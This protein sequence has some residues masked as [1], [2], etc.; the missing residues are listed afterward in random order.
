MLSLTP[1]RLELIEIA[2][3]IDLRHD[4]LD[5]FPS[6]SRYPSDS[7]ICASR[8]FPTHRSGSRH[9]SKPNLFRCTQELEHSFK[10]VPGDGFPDAD[11]KL[12]F[13]RFR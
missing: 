9:E 5:E 6:M 4:V 13:T 7:A 12:P 11:Q 1:D 2:P 10:P 3:G 8:F